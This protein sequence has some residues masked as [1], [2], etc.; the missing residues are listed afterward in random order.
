MS[1]NQVKTISN[2]NCKYKTGDK[3]AKLTKLKLDACQFGKQT[4]RVKRLDRRPKCFT[5]ALIAMNRKYSTYV[6]NA[7]GVAII[8]ATNLSKKQ[9][10]N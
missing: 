8:R 5:N 7:R 2:T 10:S 3:L 1:K 9:T 6:R 4:P